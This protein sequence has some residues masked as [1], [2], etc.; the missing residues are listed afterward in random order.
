[1]NLKYTLILV[2]VTS[3]ISAGVTRYFFARTEIQTVEVQKE[4]VKNNIQTIIKTVEKP[5][6]TKETTE[7]IEDKSVT[8]ESTMEKTVQSN[9]PQWMVDVGSRVSFS[10]KVLLYDVQVQRRILGPFFAGVKASTDKSVG[11]SIGMEF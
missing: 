11:V 1:M 7:T 2:A 9:P 8:N 6:G 10:D 4:V 5:D 3:V